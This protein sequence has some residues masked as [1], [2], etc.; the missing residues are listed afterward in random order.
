MVGLVRGLG[1]HEVSESISHTK[2]T[3][4]YT[5]LPCIVR[6]NFTLMLSYKNIAANTRTNICYFYFIIIATIHINKLLQ[7]KFL[8]SSMKDY[9]LIEIYIIEK[10]TS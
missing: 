7:L 9:Y 8:K 4:T 3:Y 1:G 2:Y 6:S 10:Y 5:K